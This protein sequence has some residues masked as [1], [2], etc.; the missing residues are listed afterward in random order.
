[1]NQSVTAL[2][3]AVKEARKRKYLSQELLAERIGVCKRTIIEIENNAGNP[4]FGMLCALV[5]ELELPLYQIFYPGVN[6]NLELKNVVLEELNHCSEYE[7]KI[8][9][10]VIR[11]LHE[12]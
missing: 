8:M 3:S 11:G 7:M 12:M 10:A 5:Q 1:M 6:E 2:G 9:L 4:K